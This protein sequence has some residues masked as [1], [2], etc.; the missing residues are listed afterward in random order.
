MPLHKA[1]AEADLGRVKFLIDNAAD[2]NTESND[3]WTALHRAA[4]FGHT[5]IVRLL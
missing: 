5:D 3:G 1:A 4:V 2:V